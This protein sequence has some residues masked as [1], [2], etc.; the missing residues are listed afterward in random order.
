MLEKM[1][2]I[3][4]DAKQLKDERGLTLVELLV[5]V[6]I[7]GI[8]AAIAVVAIGGII[9]NS[10][11]DAMVADAKQM[12]S[13]AK[14]YTASNPVK[15]DAPVELV[16]V[17]SKSDGATGA[18]GS[19]YISQLQDP[20]GKDYTTALVKITED[21]GKY[22]YSTTLVGSK[23]KIENKAEENLNKESTNLTA[24]E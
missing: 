7:L 22:K 1:N 15:K 16:F 6:V 19:T 12:V 9:E 4:Q 17:G 8:I 18:D 20:F 23:F 5:V 24:V 21:G 11:K 2:L 10:R 3:W 13:S 14:L